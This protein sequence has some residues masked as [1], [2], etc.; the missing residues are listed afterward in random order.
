[1]K[2]TRLQQD[3][4]NLATENGAVFAGKN[5]APRSFPFDDRVR[6]SHVHASTITSLIKRGLLVKTFDTDGGYAGKMPERQP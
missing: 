6:M 4:L 2:I 3:A 1:M 5:N